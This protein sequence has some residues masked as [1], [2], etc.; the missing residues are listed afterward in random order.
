MLGGFGLQL[1]GSWLA[2]NG[3]ALCKSGGMGR[4][5]AVRCV[6]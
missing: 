2:A 1:A 3:R 6:G 4:A 5:V